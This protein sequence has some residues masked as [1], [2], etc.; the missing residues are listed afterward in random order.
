MNTIINKIESFKIISDNPQVIKINEQLFYGYYLL[1][2]DDKIFSTL[3]VNPK[4]DDI[5]VQMYKI[6]PECQCLVLY[7]KTFILCTTLSNKCIRLFREDFWTW[8]NESQHYNMYIAM[9]KIKF[10]DI[11]ASLQFVES[12]THISEDNKNKPIDF[13]VLY[14]KNQKSIITPEIYERIK[15]DNK[16]DNKHIIDH[17]LSIGQFNKIKDDELKTLKNMIKEHYES[18][19]IELNKKMRS[20]KKENDDMKR[21][22]SFQEV[23]IN[24]C[25]NTISDLEKY[26]MCLGNITKEMDY[27]C[28]HCDNIYIESDKKINCKHKYI[29]NYCTS[30]IGMCPKCNTMYG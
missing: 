16:K 24:S 1:E 12:L 6:N 13:D 26:I 30:D 15:K 28:F 14:D 25:Q 29:C 17:L 9:P 20:L 7:S 18:S 3:I 11:K 5:D 27:Y 2:K 10:D 23:K 8:T 4:T 19:F 22:I 21:T